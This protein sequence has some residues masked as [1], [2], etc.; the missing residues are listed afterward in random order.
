M[1]AQI[2]QAAPCP[3]ELFVRA[4]GELPPSDLALLRRAAGTSFGED[5]LVYDLFREMCR[6]I[7]RKIVY[8]R[9]A[10]YLLATLY[11]WHQEVSE[12]CAN[13]SLGTALGRAAAPPEKDDHDRADMRME[14]LLA[15]RGHE[16]DH[17]VG[18]A[19]RYLARKE[20]GFGWVR[21]LHDLVKW[22]SP[23]ER[24]QGEWAADYYNASKRK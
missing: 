15:S 6:P 21:L 5:V 18:Q 7:W 12:E 17:Q 9:R 19:V 1:T 11:P 13:H 24:T 10:Y 16:L 22:Y 3:E 23:G 20:I 14:Q 4:L 2:V 8:K